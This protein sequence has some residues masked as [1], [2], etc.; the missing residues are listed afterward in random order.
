MP[1]EEQEKNYQ[2]FQEQLPKLLSDPLKKGKHATIHKQEIKGIF[3][4]FE[5]AYRDACLKGYTGFIIQQI[6]D[7]NDIVEYL[8][9]AV[10]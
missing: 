5:A 3:D 4:T 1:S 10:V 9:A 2:F 6:I 7:E 8:S